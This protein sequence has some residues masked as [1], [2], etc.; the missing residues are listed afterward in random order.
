MKMYTK[1]NTYN[2]YCDHG[3][4]FKMAETAVAKAN[5]LVY[6]CKNNPK[7]SSLCQK[8]YSVSSRKM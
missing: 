8:L 4:V 5:K 7:S 2:L 3:I 6:I 1:Y